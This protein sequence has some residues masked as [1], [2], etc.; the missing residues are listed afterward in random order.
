MA[1]SLVKDKKIRLRVVTP[2]HVVYD[3]MVDI[4]I[5]RTTDGDLGVMYGHEPCTALLGDGALR[6]IPDQRGKEQE[7]LMI[8]GG[9]LTVGE[10]I[11][12]VM[13]DIAQRPDQIEEYMDRLKKEKE[14]N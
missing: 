2:L 4:A 10:N 5:A 3:G 1:D 13:S 7:L 11:A 14:E 6:I 12:V 9:I 8:L